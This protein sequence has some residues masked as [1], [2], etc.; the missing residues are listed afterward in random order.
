[1]K[2]Q[3]TGLDLVR[4]LNRERAGRVTFMPLDTL[5]V[6]RVEYP[7]EFGQDA[8][9]LYKH[10]KFDPQFESA[11][12]QVGGGG[13]AMEGALL[14]DEIPIYSWHLENGDGGDAWEGT[15]EWSRQ[16]E[17]KAVWA[18]GLECVGNGAHIEHEGGRG[19]GSVQ[20]NSPEAS[21]KRLTSHKDIN[22]QELGMD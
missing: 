18:A 19:A 6:P 1:M 7:K 17:E 11:V 21:D 16:G 22:I 3:S 9:P 2:D 12:R 4:A 13:V 14:W 5:H 15:S 20:K 10:I 8:V